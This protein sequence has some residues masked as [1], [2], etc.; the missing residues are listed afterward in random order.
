MLPAERNPGGGA[1]KLAGS[2]T[3][4]PP[5]FNKGDWLEPDSRCYVHVPFCRERCAYCHFRSRTDLS[6]VPAWQQGI[7]AGLLSL[8]AGESRHR[9]TT[10]YVG[11]GT[12]SLLPPELLADVLRAA[13]AAFPALRE[14]TVE[15][16]VADLRGD[17]PA[18]L[19]GMGVNRLS[20]GVQ[21][22]S[23]ELRQRLGR[24]NADASPERGLAATAGFPGSISVDLIT[25]MESQTELQARDDVLRA[26]D[27]GARHLSVYDLSPPPSETRHGDGP[28]RRRALLE[29]A[30]AAATEAGL[31]RY[32]I[33]NYAAAGHES[34]HN[35][36]YWRL[37]TWIGLGEGAE[38]RVRRGGG[39]LT[40]RERRGGVLR[41]EEHTPQQ[42]FRDYVIAAIRTREGISTG[43]A[44]W[45]A[46][47]DVST[48]LI[49]WW[50]QDVPGNLRETHGTDRLVLSPGG[51][52][53]ENTLLRA[54]LDR[55]AG[56]W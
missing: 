14:V 3:P 51:W 54:F 19:A 23:Q 36:N 37:G 41:V 17:L 30:G 56:R 31:T 5:D 53:V 16:H 4:D 49:E 2:T 29:A 34:A 52:M 9:V 38:G 15:C 20:I 32:E 6:G 42:A 28:A 26:L 44:S 22:F 13:N 33:S 46:G 45:I 25:G 7:L 1:T 55:A 47:E 39:A 48:M 8:G 12:P 18:R 43:R 35:R 27:A 40:W 11:G 21:S 10:L 50:E 24:C